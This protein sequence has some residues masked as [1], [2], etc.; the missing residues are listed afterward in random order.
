MTATIRQ[1]SIDEVA[2]LLG[3]SRRTIE[4]EIASRRLKTV[5]IG[6]RRLIRETTLA[7]YQARRER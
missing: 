5:R 6:D 7:D 2:A 4:R 1:Y 3:V